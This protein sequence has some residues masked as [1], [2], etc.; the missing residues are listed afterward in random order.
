M[1]DI[2]HEYDD[3]RKLQPLHGKRTVIPTADEQF[4][5]MADPDLDLEEEE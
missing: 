4:D 1:T 2:I 3:N 5:A